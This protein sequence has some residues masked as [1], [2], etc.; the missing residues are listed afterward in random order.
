MSQTTDRCKGEGEVSQTASDNAV[1]DPITYDIIV[2]RVDPRPPLHE[3]I[4]DTVLDIMGEAVAVTLGLAFVWFGA[5]ATLVERG[6]ADLT[7]LVPNAEMWFAEAYEGRAAEIGNL[8]LVVDSE[9]GEL[10]V[11]GRDIVV[12]DDMG[13]ELKSLPRLRA[14]LDLSA[15]LSGRAELLR[16][17]T[18]G[19]AITLRRRTAGW[20][21]GLGT[22]DNLG[23]LGPL[24]NL[25]GGAEGHAPV[26][27]VRAR[28]FTLYILDEVDGGAT[29]IEGADL[30]FRGAQ[31][32][33]LRGVLV[34]GED[35]VPLS[36]QRDGDT[37]RINLDGLRPATL[38]TER[39]PL[40][41]LSL[42]DAP[43]RADLTFEGKAAEGDISIGKGML[44][45]GPREIALSSMEATGTY[46][47][48]GKLSLSGFVLDS[49][50]L[51]TAG[52]LDVQRS[53][54]GLSGRFVLSDTNV[55]T[56]KALGRRLNLLTPKGRFAFV[57][58]TLDLRNLDI[59]IGDA[60]FEGDIS[61]DLEGT[62]PVA[63]RARIDME[64]GMGADELLA[65]WP[66]GFVGGARRWIERAIID[67]RIRNIRATADLPRAA[68]EPG[69]VMIDGELNRRPIPEDAMDVTFDVVDGR[70]R[71]IST[72][73]PLEGARGRGR[74]RGNSFVFDLD[75]GT[76]GTLGV[77][78]ATV[79]MPR[80]VPKGGPFTVDV[81]GS[82]SAPD[83]LRLIDEE[84]FRFAT[85]YNLV[86]DEFSGQGEVSLRI[87]RPLREFIT[88]DQVDYAVQGSFR[89]VSVPF[90]LF[91]TSL[92][93]GEVTLQA[94]ATRLQ[95][96]GPVSF[97]PWR[98]DLSYDDTLGDEGVNPT[99]AR[100]S[101]TL[102]RDALDS[103]GIGMRKYFDGDIP[104][105]IDALSDGLNLLSADVF[106]DLTD[107]T[108][109][110]DPYWAKPKGISS[111]LTLSVR[112]E[113]DITH[114]DDV[115]I[116]APGMTLEGEGALRL[117]G[118]LERARL[119]RLF[120]RD[121]MD[122]N[123]LVVPNADRSRLDVTVGGETL[124][125]S[126]AVAERLQNPMA[127]GGLPIDLQGRFGALKLAEDYVLSGAEVMFQSDGA[128]VERA[129]IAGEIDGEL[130]AAAIT[131]SETG[132]DLSISLPDA[133]GAA[134]ALFG[135]RGIK[136]GEMK[137]DASLP[138][139][140]E[141]GAVLGE[142]EI[143]DITLN[144]AP[145]LA[146]MLSLAS[147]SGLGD[148]L[149]GQGLRF[150]D[151]ESEFGYRDGVLSL[152]K[153]RASGP[154]L[155]LTVEGEVG[156]GAKVIDLNGVLVPAYTANS[157]LG[158]IPLIGD[159]LVGREGEGIVS[160]SWVAQGPYDAA[161]VAVNPLSALTPGFTREIF[162]PQRDDIE[163]MVADEDPA[164]EGG[165]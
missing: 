153:T 3:R 59:G 119:S 52:T 132:R 63:I 117:S 124:D 12:R 134:E 28:D 110:L 144:R 154:A 145:I 95:I 22:P 107:A 47:G 111:G 151:V 125:L 112:R 126:P 38:A 62:K 133:S 129:R 93:D 94:D 65:L 24:T 100:L 86:P 98:A 74:L 108:L 152:R 149:S 30:T 2:E 92:T 146:Q 49:A 23:K 147:L 16:L 79:T 83:M 25:G 54:T 64:G 81:E 71:Y 66:E 17:D 35:S 11:L 102:S 50:P 85:L 75:A 113:G 7:A 39:G 97:G 46:D 101:G 19:G 163:E 8:R 84:P 140:G 5:M 157:L 162:K 143:E 106:A 128:G 131:P 109:S 42:L 15:A 14:D 87:T 73:T 51:R 44:R 136:G 36:L 78:E 135:W 53:E 127:G 37:T 57:D 90:S 103:F 40:A 61:T 156:L 116:T 88:P 34:T 26:Q 10:T 27:Q 104:V 6:G 31:D 89:N 130:A 9:A 148:T 96:Q 138:P 120:I 1:E 150:K 165:P 43:V 139:V 115:R 159:I 56:R 91:G 18:E 29:R 72:M 33:G 82:G 20:Q 123:A 114:A 76:V 142:V 80:L 160:L 69:Q 55:D 68:L 158:D 21:A 70:V 67:G 48:E 32:V 77:R 58:G 161:Q 105:T 121:V 141:P 4:A 60:R 45:M 164:E 41:R 137:L 155:G 13:G 118:Q 99:R 122:I